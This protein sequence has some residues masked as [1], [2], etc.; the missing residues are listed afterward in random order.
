[1]FEHVSPGTVKPGDEYVATFEQDMYLQG[2]EYLLSM[3]C[4][5]YDATGFTAYHR[6]YD[7]CNV[8]VISDK[9]TVGYYDMNSTVTVERLDRQDD[10]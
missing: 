3:S 7:V 4:T 10:I 5:G 6:L 2:G 1:M 8:T 9:D